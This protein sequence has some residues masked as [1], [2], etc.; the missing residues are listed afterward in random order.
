MS[1]IELKFL[2]LAQIGIDI[3]IVI[4]FVFLIRRFR[5]NNRGTSFNKPVKIFESLLADAERMAGQFEEQ[6]EEKHHLI[7]KLN[8]ELDKRI[9]SLNI[10]LNRADVL[11]SNGKDSP[12]TNDRPVSLDDQQKEI[13]ELEKKGHSAEKIATMLSIPKGEVML[14]LGLK[15]KFSQMSG[16]ESYNK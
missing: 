15:K 1:F 14:V 2:I 8:K 7:K 9:I 5:Y 13:L 4:L 6:L 10:M 12:D 3:L 16:N 11:L